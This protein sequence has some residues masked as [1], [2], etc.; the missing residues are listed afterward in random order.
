MIGRHHALARAPFILPM[1]INQPG[2]DSIN[3]RERQQ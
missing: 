3:Q 2:R 1:D